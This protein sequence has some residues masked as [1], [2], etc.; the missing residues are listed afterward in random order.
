MSNKLPEGYQSLYIGYPGDGSQIIFT[1]A[2]DYEAR[3]FI[4][5]ECP[6]V[7]SCFKTGATIVANGSYEIRY[8]FMG[9]AY[10][11]NIMED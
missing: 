11:K 5:S 9:L 2:S 4:E 3:K 6:R 8:G 1:A 10:N 7:K